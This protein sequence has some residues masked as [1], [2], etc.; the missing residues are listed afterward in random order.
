[1]ALSKRRPD[2]TLE[3][4]LVRQMVLPMACLAAALGVG[5]SVWQ[6]RTLDTLFEAQGRNAA[7]QVAALVAASATPSATGLPLLPSDGALQAALRSSGSQRV[8]IRAPERARIG[9][10]LSLD[11][12]DGM[13]RFV[14]VWPPADGSTP[15]P[16]GAAA[17]ANEAARPAK[18]TAASAQWE[19]AIW[20]DPTGYHRAQAQGVAV[21]GASV[22][23]LV[24]CAWVWTRRSARA[25]ELSLH[26]LDTTLDAIE[27]GHSAVRYPQTDPVTALAASTKLTKPPD[28]FLWLGDRITALTERLNQRQYASAERVRQAT[29]AALVRLVQVEQIELSRARQL[30][31]TGHDLRQPLHAMGLLIDGLLDSA[32]TTQIPAL[33]RLRESTLFI[34]SL[35]DDLMEIA[36]LDAAVI[37][38]S[39]TTVSVTAVFERLQSHFSNPVQALRLDL[40]WRARGFTVQAD[41]QLLQRLLQR[42]VDN[43]VHRSAGGK[44]MVAVR[45]AGPDAVQ[46]EVRDS[47]IGM[48]PI[49]HQRIF[50]AFYQV[51]DI[52]PSRRRG[53][54]LG[55]A[56]AGR[57]AHL[58]GTRIQ[59]RSALHMGSTFTIK[60]PGSAPPS[61]SNRQAAAPHTGGIAVNQPH[62]LLIH[63]DPDT[64]ETHRAW[65]D[66]WGYRVT[67]MPSLVDAVAALD[68]HGASFQVVLSALALDPDCVDSSQVL[69]AAQRR[70]SGAL[71]IHIGCPPSAAQ[72]LVWR[73]RGVAMLAWPVAPA[74]LRALIATR[75]PLT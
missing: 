9:A 39:V 26:R 64:L 41:P 74:K 29:A 42:L 50:E 1:M 63:D 31:A 55:L 45:Q 15:S 57:I 68:A 24:L 43:A 34:R 10:G 61:P 67:C 51:P 25:M 49:H 2:P 75:W 60:L 20:R 21:A 52:E 7:W 23:L 47:G 48:A 5:Y 32:S 69:D 46:I 11:A 14:V 37:P 4:A 65:L 62:C 54:G 38:S 66:R 17:G 40:R 33:E 59:L 13:R 12:L 71:L 73:E 8:E 35:F 19:V 28:E 36:Q 72:A 16:N 18:P 22:L 6:W 56:I 70:C 53:F 3:A 27:A 44:V 30:N 58:M